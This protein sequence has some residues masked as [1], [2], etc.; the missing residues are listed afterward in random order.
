MSLVR[1]A[2]ECS[3]NEAKFMYF[4]MTLTNESDLHDE[5]EQRLNMENACY[6]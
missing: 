5:T 2:N 6:L 1:T 4:G 3:E